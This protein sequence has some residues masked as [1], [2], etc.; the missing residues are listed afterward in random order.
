ML[1]S[2]WNGPIFERAH[3]RELRGL[4]RL[5]VRIPNLNISL[6]PL[7]GKLQTLEVLDL[8]SH[9]VANLQGLQGLVALRE[10]ILRCTPVTNESFEGLEQLLARLYKLDL[11]GCTLLE[12]ISNLAPATSLRE[13]NL[14]DSRVWGLRGLEELVALETLD[15]SRIP[16]CDWSILRQCP[17]L[18]ALTAEVRDGAFATTLVEAMMDSAAA[19]VYAPPDEIQTTVDSAAHCL[20]RWR[21]HSSVNERAAHRRLKAWENLAKRGF[22][23]FAVLRELDIRD[24]GV[25]SESI[26]GLAELPALEVLNLSNN[27]LNDVRALAGCRAL[28]ELSLSSTLVTDEGI[29]G[30]QE[31][32][33]LQKL[34]LSDCSNLTSVT[35]LR[36]C[37]SLRELSLGDTPITDAGIEGL[38][39]IAT[40]TR[41]SLPRCKLLTS[42][43]TLRGSPSLRE[44]DISYTE[45]TETGI[46]GLEEIGTLEH[47]DALCCPSLDDVTSLRRCRALRYLYL[48]QTSVTDASMA[49]LA[50][51][52]TL[53]TLDLSGCQ[54][55]RNVSALS[56]SVSLREMDLSYTNVDNAGIAGLERIPTL[57]SLCLGRCRRISDVTKL[58]RSKSLRRLELSCSP[59]TE[60][61]IVGIETAPA[62]EFLELHHCSGIADAEGVARRAAECAVALNA[63]RHR[64]DRGSWWS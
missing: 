13:L 39:H 11:R 53:A 49:A 9:P 59:V 63:S 4:K 8:T 18:T 40:L 3:L 20:V 7:I 48:A 55:I 41:L 31:I 64:R 28:R 10:L 14:A 38:G 51:V 19:S 58:I 45:V 1:D 62:L 60:E 35:N 36:R 46:A 6:V 57:T 27:P 24:I 44:L 42:V 22:L 52:A 17:R 21:L 23:R 12:A 30:L 50:C 32:V 43:S 2:S 56:G 16:A 54:Q 26:R 33:T 37:A 15:V 34:D 5:R 29:A 25:K 61:G 47:L